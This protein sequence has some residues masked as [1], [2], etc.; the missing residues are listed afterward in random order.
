MDEKK[1]KA[2]RDLLLSAEKSVQGAK[3]I[4]AG[5]LPE[6]ESASLDILDTSSLSTYAS[7]EDKI[8]EGVFTG[9]AMLGSDK[10]LYPVPQ[11]Y[12]SKSLLVQG[13]RLKATIKPNG[14]IIYKIIEE[15]EYDTIKGLITKD[16][17]KY[18]VVADTRV[19][20]VLLAAITFTRA[21]VGDTVSIRIP[22]GKEATFAAIVAVI[23]K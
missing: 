1:L 18:Q 16:K 3:R 7:D 2:I 9:E 11:N 17:E 13:S 5:M 15:M 6:G 12:A 23:P 10:N 4:L 21:E 8:V 19:Y 22:R 20:G 14:K